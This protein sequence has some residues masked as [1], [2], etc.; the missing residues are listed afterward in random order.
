MFIYKFILCFLSKYYSEKEYCPRSALFIWKYILNKHFLFYIYHKYC[1]LNLVFFIIICLYVIHTHDR[2]LRTTT[3]TLPPINRYL[4]VE[5]VL[6][7]LYDIYIHIHILYSIIS[8]ELHFFW[9]YDNF[10]FVL[11]SAYRHI[12]ILQIQYL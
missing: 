4:F 3:F 7:Y 9:K 8:Y 10:D 11:L 1:I 2:S 12:I 6:I 5:T